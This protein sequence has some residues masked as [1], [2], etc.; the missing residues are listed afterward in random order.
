MDIAREMTTTGPMVTKVT[1]GI[2]IIVTGMVG[3]REA[4]D[5]QGVEEEEVVF[6]SKDIALRL[7]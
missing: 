4:G 2:T 6:F 3:L 1:E 7:P 5:H